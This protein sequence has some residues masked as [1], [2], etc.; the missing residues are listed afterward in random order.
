MR[1]LILSMHTFNVLWYQMSLIWIN[2][3]TFLFSF[4]SLFLYVSI[5]G[6]GSSNFKVDDRSLP[7]VHCWHFLN[8]NNNKNNV[9]DS[10]YIRMQCRYFILVC[11]PVTNH[12]YCS[13]GCT[14]IMYTFTGCSYNI[15]FTQILYTFTG[16][17]YNIGF[18]QMLYTCKGCTYNIDFTQI[19][20]T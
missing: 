19:W 8:F 3:L 11:L 5:V 2:I 6:L 16:C 15:G 20:Y 12:G 17:S 13:I 4:S 9:C 10:A 7:A 14:Q 18:M 1:A